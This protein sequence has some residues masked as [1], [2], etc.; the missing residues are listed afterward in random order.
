MATHAAGAGGGRDVGGDGD[1]L[2]LA[3]AL[4][5][6][7]AEGHALGAGGDGVRGVLHVG[8]VE[9]DAVDGDQGRADPELAVRA[10][11]RRF[12]ADAA[13]VQFPELGLGEPVLP[14]RRLDRGGVRAG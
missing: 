2:D 13:R 5:H 14:A 10:V 11:R 9:E 8:A 12:G 3:V 4:G 1:G 7:L 6:G